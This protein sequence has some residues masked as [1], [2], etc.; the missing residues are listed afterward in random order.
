MPQFNPA[1]HRAV[2]GRSN[3]QI[4]V[5]AKRLAL[6]NTAVI[7]RIPVVP[8]VNDSIPE[9]GALCKF[10]QDLVELRM[11][12]R[13]GHGRPA[14]IQLQLLPFHRLA[15]ENYRSLGLEYRAQQ[16]EPPSKAKL[17]ELAKIAEIQ[18]LDVLVG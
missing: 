2:C 17:H 14:P 11:H 9:I 18:G 7:F 5:N 15:A 3:E 10:V 13:N 8:T 12:H 4:L 16:L 6:T 1:K